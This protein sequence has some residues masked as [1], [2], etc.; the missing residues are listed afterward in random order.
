LQLAI[1]NGEKDRL[2]QLIEQVGEQNV[3]ISQVLK[4][5]AERYDYEAL[6]HLL[7]GAAV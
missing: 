2:D 4:D 3:A 1:R 5:L 6:T 7:E